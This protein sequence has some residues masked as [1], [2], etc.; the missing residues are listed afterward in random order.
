M[1]RMYIC[2]CNAVTERQVR[3]CVAEGATTLEDLQIDL[4]VAMCCGTCA[5]TARS[6]LPGGCDN[7]CGMAESV[8]GEP[9]PVRWQVLSKAA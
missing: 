9:L 2:V 8:G 5:D 4:G 3:A 6:Y 1:L 7:S